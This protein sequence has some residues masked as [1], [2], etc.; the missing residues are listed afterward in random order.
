MNSR[1]LALVA[2][3][4][5]SAC[6]FGATNKV[7]QAERIAQL[8]GFVT[9]PDSQKGSVAIINTQ[10]KVDVSKPMDEI[11]SFFTRVL[12]IKL[13]VVK[14]DAGKPEELKAKSGAKYVVI[15][16]DDAALPTSLIA[17]EEGYAVVNVAK[18]TAN[19][20]LPDDNEIYA[21]RCARG[22]MK[23]FV[24]LCGGGGSRYPGTV[25][26][27]HSPR[28]LDAAQDK[29]PID[30]QDSIKKFLDAAG[31]TPLKR[32]IY[33]RACMEGWAPAPTNDIQKAI[34]E[35]VKADKE[36]GPTNPIKIAPP[37]K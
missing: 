17:P 26:S 6:A 19:L 13:N 15:I 28:E 16:A 31:I 21:R 7:S 33:R 34:Y 18:Y 29:I 1:N 8:G 37:R 11:F 25:A 24:L 2:L 5:T 3:A 36:K 32:T 14:M 4:M 23:A 35:Q 27:T 12:P 20:K 30:T 22:V 9:Y 10:S